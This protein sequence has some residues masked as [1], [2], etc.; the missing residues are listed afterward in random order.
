MSEEE[1]NDVEDINLDEFNFDD[2][3]NDV[4]VDSAVATED[5]FEDISM[6]DIDVEGDVNDNSTVLEGQR[7][8]PFFEMSNEEVI[9]E[10]SDQFQVVDID[11]C[12]PVITESDVA[13]VEIGDEFERQEFDV[14]ENS[15]EVI[16]LKEDSDIISSD[17]DASGEEEYGVND[18][19]Q[20]DDNGN[21]LPEGFFVDEGIE[22]EPIQDETF[23]KEDI[24]QAHSEYFAS[25]NVEVVETE[26]TAGT[27]DKLDLPSI[28]DVGNI[29]YLKWYSG[30]LTDKMFKIEKGFES[31]TFYADEECKTI[32]VNVGYDTY[33]WEVQF[34][35]GVV[36][37]LRDVREYQI[38]NGKLPSSDGRIIYANSTLM[39][40]GVERIVIYESVK[41]FSYGI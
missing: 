14:G 21:D 20:Q 10:N 12:V 22:A 13:D 26:L 9:V 23:S 1:F 17:I 4:E 18:V 27:Y 16:E 29:G 24:D 5:V 30:S 11:D 7:V 41:Y 25:D 6:D 39:F 35:D 33:G 31:S 32:H 2:L 36:M 40:S 8:E 34:S 3:M 38:R 15:A 37:N 28:L 19:V